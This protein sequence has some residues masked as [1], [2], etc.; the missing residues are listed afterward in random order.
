MEN[1][2]ARP[3]IGQNI[4]NYTPENRFDKNKE[5]PYFD[6]VSYFNH[7]APKI[8]LS[9]TDWRKLGKAATHLTNCMGLKPKSIKKI[10]DGKPEMVNTYP[11]KVLF[12]ILHLNKNILGKEPKDLEI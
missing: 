1:R 10:V 12:P 11:V 8:H 5:E 9:H 2:P 7:K 6:L 3:R 4:Q